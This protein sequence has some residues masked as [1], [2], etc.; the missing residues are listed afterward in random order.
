MK[1]EERLTL[2]KAL[3]TNVFSKPEERLAA[4]KALENNDEN[5]DDLLR[6]VQF[7]T[8]TKQTS[9]DEIAEQTTQKDE[10]F[11]YETGADS[12]LRALLSFGETDRDQEA[13]LAKLVGMGGFTRD[14]AGRLALTP[15]GQRVR[16][17]EPKGKK[18]L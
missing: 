10:N 11:D 17:L 6:A 9:F 8:L 12:G 7:N 15:A 4:F 1:P 5:V 18:T 2:F 3:E 13:I 16:G 14:S